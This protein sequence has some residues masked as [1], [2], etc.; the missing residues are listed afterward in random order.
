MSTADRVIAELVTIRET[1]RTG[2]AVSHLNW[3]TRERCGAIGGAM[4]FW[5]TDAAAITATVPDTHDGNLFGDVVS[6]ALDR[7]AELAD[8]PFNSALISKVSDHEYLLTW[9]V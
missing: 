5:K 9:T 7:A 2:E 1:Y 6:E 4:A 3:E 8:V